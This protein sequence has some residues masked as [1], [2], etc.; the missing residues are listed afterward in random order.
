MPD[1][2]PDKY[3]ILESRIGHHFADAHILDSA[4]THKSFLN[5]N[6]QAGRPDNERLEF[7][8]DA[9]LALTIGH[10]LMDRFPARREGELSLARS[11][12]VSEAGLSPVAEAIS[13]GEWLYLGRGEEQTGGR[14]KPSLLADALEALIAAVYLDAGL[15][16]AFAVIR[17]LFADRIEALASSGAADFKTRLQERAQGQFHQT[18][19]YQVVG[20]RGPDHD[21]VF[22]V[23]IL[24]G[25]QEVARGE[26]RSKK[27]AEQ[28]AAE[29]A[30]G[31]LDPV[32]NEDED[33]DA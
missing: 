24:L 25:G 29:R 28:R 13:L 32:G 30:L 4:L 1:D 23:A 2:G 33:A 7:L 6:P 8:G 26:G 15:P 21:K 12:I 22:E 18:P 10:L 16:A 19:R 27:E 14:R 20:E 5:E 3:A 9:V 17:R 31:V 11:A